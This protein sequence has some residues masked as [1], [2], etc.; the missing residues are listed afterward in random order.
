M[1]YI[2]RYV[3][4][5]IF[6]PDISLSIPETNS[7]PLYLFLSCL[8]LSICLVYH[9]LCYL[10]DNFELTSMFLSFFFL[11]ISLFSTSLYPIRIVSVFFLVLFSQW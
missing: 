4:L 11:S 8:I 7:F 10:G 6:D 3:F 9:L 1:I 5:F 2:Y